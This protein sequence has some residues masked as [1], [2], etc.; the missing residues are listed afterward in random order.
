V[1]PF[2]RRRRQRKLLLAA[3]AVYPFSTAFSFVGLIAAQ[4]RAIPRA[5]EIV[6]ATTLASIGWISAAYVPIVGGPA[7][8]ALLVLERF[9]RPANGS[10]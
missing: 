6:S 9:T 3:V 10:A 8:V 1:A 4:D 7:L 2:V 5:A